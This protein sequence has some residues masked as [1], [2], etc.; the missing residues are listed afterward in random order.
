MVGEWEWQVTGRKGSRMTSPC[1]VTQW[2]VILSTRMTTARGGGLK[3]GMMVSVG[4][5]YV[6][7]PH[8]VTAMVLEVG[9]AIMKQN[10]EALCSHG[11]FG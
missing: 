4:Q 10:G 2:M 3:E 9:Y 11:A 6:S 8:S 5:K 1:W 7:S